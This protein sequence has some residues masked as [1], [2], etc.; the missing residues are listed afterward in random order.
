MRAVLLSAIAT[1]L[2][3]SMFS[4]AAHAERFRELDYPMPASSSETERRPAASLRA[5]SF[6]AYRRDDG[7]PSATVAPKAGFVGTREGDMDRD[8]PA[9][10]GEPGVGR[11]LVPYDGRAPLSRAFVVSQ[12]PDDRIVLAGQIGEAGA[13]GGLGTRIGI[14]QLTREGWR[15]SSF[16]DIGHQAIDLGNP[17]IEV[18][19]GAGLTENLHGI[20]YDRIYLLG[21]DFELSSGQNFALMCFRRQVGAPLFEAC[22]DFPGG[23]RYY[24]VGLAASCATD[25]SIP[26]GLYLHRGNAAGEER[27][28]LVGQARRTI[29][30]CQDF[31][32]AIMRLRL[33]GAP[34][35]AFG[36]TGMI[37]Y[38]V[39]DGLSVDIALARSATVRSDGKLLVGGSTG[40][41]PAERAVVAQFHPSGAVDSA[42]CASADSEC[43]SPLS[44]RNGRR[45]F[46]SESLGAVTA[47][48]PTSGSGVF[49]VRRVGAATQSSRYAVIQRMDDLGRCL[50]FCDDLDFGPTAVFE[51]VSA[52]WRPTGTLAVSTITVASW[53]HD[54]DAH[55]GRAIVHRF[56]TT[57]GGSLIPDDQFVTQP[58]GYRQEITWPNSDGARNA[59]VHAMSLDRQGRVMLAASVAA[60]AT[61]RDMGIAR[62]QGK[63][64]LFGDGFEN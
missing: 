54:A 40:T 45:S 12:R 22:P 18:V 39:P 35:T 43:P 53:G 25:D 13:P 17:R 52:I 60:F 8:L 59:R 63:V 55:A 34:D 1:A 15:D 4:A 10:N 41:G 37:T 19:A 51:P 64:Q 62:L 58:F 56:R 44:H 42:F 6:G 9:H 23:V 38:W 50:V 32:W 24:R 2:A 57:S 21:R 36:G 46:N 20:L 47:L 33:N 14:V 11:Y 29:N 7:T 26:A 31:D 5:P 61:E 3:A 49:T 48:A 28:Y 30:S 16:N 27:L